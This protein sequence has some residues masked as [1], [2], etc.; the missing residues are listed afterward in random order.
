[1]QCEVRRTYDKEILLTFDV[2]GKYYGKQLRKPYEEEEV[3]S[4]DK[5]SS[6]VLKPDSISS[7]QT[8]K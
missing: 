4:G 8:K 5:R 6:E 1:L 3:S 2:S 7:V